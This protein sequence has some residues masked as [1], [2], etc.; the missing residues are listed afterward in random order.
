MSDP[1]ITRSDR[2][3]AER[4]PSESATAWRTLL[5]MAR[6][7]ATR[8]N[9]FAAV[10]ALI[11]GFAIV[12]QVQQTQQ[13]GL[14]QLREPELIRI[15]DDVTQDSNRLDTEAQALE[16]TR[17]GLLSSSASDEAL[18]AA[19]ERLDALSILA[20]T[21]PATGPGIT[22]RI[23]DPDSAI[24]AALVLDAIQELR[25][26]GAE[27]IQVGEVR[28][29]ASTAFTDTDGGIEVDGVRVAPPYEIRAIGDA[30]TM[31]A[32]MDIP[33]GVSESVRGVGAAPSVSQSDDLSITALHA[34]S[35]PRYALPVPEASSTPN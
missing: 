11:L 21:T 13:E 20:G 22:L 23:V 31:A 32:A 24:R 28:V 26:A 1:D 10:L 12:T 18:T 7:R 6:P 9:A 15:L 2:R 3:E 4:E 8:A 33:G 25:D 35:E 5:R 19:R 14:E 30:P 34:P 29:V 27:V 17:Q 16:R